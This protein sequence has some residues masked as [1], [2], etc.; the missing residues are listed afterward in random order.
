MKKESL[1][2]GGSYHSYKKGQKEKDAG[3]ILLQIVHSYTEENELLSLTDGRYHRNVKNA[4][5][6][7]IILRGE[8]GGR[9]IQC[10][11]SNN[12]QNLRVCH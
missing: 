6:T 2:W 3:Q 9:S 12:M 10:N 4:E 7:A 1:V 11:T 8:T 5:H